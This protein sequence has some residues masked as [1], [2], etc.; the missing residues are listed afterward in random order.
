MGK[1]TLNKL[2]VSPVGTPAKPIAL[3][4]CLRSLLNEAS[5]CELFFFVSCL[6]ALKL[7]HEVTEQAKQDDGSRWVG[8]GS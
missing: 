6:M 3:H 7:S 2:H 4:E 5:R 1:L 8:G